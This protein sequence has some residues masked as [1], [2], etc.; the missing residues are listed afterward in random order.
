MNGQNYELYIRTSFQGKIRQILPKFDFC[1]EEF[2]LSE[3]LNKIQVAIT[4]TTIIFVFNFVE[5][6]GPRDVIQLFMS[7]LKNIKHQD[8]KIFE[9][10]VFESHPVYLLFSNIADILY[11]YPLERE[12]DRTQNDV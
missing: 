4:N 12:L 5:Y 2:K 1:P 9:T 6:N 7:N 10:D 11:L 3:F 8:K